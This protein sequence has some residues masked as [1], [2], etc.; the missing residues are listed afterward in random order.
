LKR[1]FSTADGSK[2]QGNGFPLS[3][4]LI[5]TAQ[6]PECSRKL[7]KPASSVLASFRPST[8]PRGYASALHSLRPCL[9][10][11]AS[12]RAGVGRVRSLDFLSI[13]RDR[14]P[15]V[16]CVRTIKVLTCQSTFTACWRAL[17]AT[18]KHRAPPTAVGLATVPHGA[19]R[20]P[21]P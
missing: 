19:G 9:G 4:R 1:A 17:A 6:N 11:G 8:Y 5:R 12:W 16:P 13:L 21:R 15:V 7:K 20:T 10:R 14:S 18:T 2:A 3:P